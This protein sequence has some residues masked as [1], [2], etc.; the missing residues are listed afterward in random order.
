MIQNYHVQ[1]QDF[2]VHQAGDRGDVLLFVHGFP[3]SH[4]Q[5]HP[6]IERFSKNY[7]VL[8]PDLRGMGGSTIDDPSAVVTME[9][10]ADDLNAL[11]DQL[12]VSEPVVL[13][14]LSMGGYVAWQMVKRHPGR[15]KGLVQCHTRIIADTPAAAADRHNLAAKIL[16]EQSSQ[17]AEDAFLPKL[18]P[19]T[20]PPVLGEQVR[21][22]ARSATPAGLAANLRGLAVREDAS[23][24]LPTI[25]VPTQVISGEHDPISPPEEMQGWATKI[26]GARFETLR[27]VGHVSPLEAP[28]EFNQCLAEFLSWCTGT[29]S[30]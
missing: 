26:G 18:L 8:A 10:H 19:P 23:A 20:A 3:M 4:A 21:Q 25:R 24:I 29:T 22:M 13:I 11:L 30:R 1:G 6:Q 17:P 2:R 28:D 9:Q 27:G 16:K 5:W 7:R 12:K 15:L 14:G